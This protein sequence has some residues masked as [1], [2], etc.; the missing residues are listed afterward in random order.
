[1]LEWY[2]MLAKMWSPPCM[3]ALAKFSA[4]ELIPLPWGPPIIHVQLLTKDNFSQLTLSGN[5]HSE[6]PCSFTKKPAGFYKN[7]R[8]EDQSAQVTNKR[9]IRSSERPIVQH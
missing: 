9:Y 5:L 6:F 2:S 4:T 3:Q 7:L 8:S 1:M